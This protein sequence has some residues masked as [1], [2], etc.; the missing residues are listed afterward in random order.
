VKVPD[1]P[2]IL[3]AYA[4]QLQSVGCGFGAFGAFGGFGGA[5]GTTGATGAAGA[6]LA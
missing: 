2:Q 5:T 6:H 1:D 4:A 3:I